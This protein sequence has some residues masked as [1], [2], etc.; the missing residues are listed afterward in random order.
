MEKELVDR[1]KQLHQQLQ[2]IK[3]VDEKGYELLHMLH[4]DIQRFL[5]R[6][7][8]MS[9]QEV[10][11]IDKLK[12]AVDYF[13]QSHPTLVLSLKQTIDTLTNMGI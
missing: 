4:D 6:E 5:E 8:D 10:T 9:G 13:E 7:E 1:L 12:E 3:S 2:E 11:F